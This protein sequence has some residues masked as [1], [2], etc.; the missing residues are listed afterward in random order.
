MSLSM[1]NHSILETQEAHGCS[2]WDLREPLPFP[3]RRWQPG[4]PLRLPGGPCTPPLGLAPSWVDT[5]R[6]CRGNKSLLQTGGQPWTSQGQSW[7]QAWMGSCA[8]SGNLGG[9]FCPFQGDP[10][11][12]TEEGAGKQ[13]ADSTPSEISPLGSLS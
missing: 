10:Q 4:F 3:G 9:Q 1:K 7:A 11:G 5:I 8:N 12:A 6:F 2:R 13:C